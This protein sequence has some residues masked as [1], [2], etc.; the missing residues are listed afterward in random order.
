MADK[1]MNILCNKLGYVYRITPYYPSIFIN[2]FYIQLYIPIRKLSGT[3]K[4]LL[5]DAIM[6]ISD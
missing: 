1:T 3:S 5:W 4:D 6:V 2:S